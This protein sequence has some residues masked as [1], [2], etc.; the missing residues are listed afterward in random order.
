MAKHKSVVKPNRPL[1]FVDESGDAGLKFES[2]SSPFF[3]VTAVVFDS[4]AESQRCLELI[5]QLRL[6]EQMSARDEFHFN[7]CD[8]SQRARFLAAIREFDFHFS[9]VVI[10]KRNLSFPTKTKSGVVMAALADTAAREL[11]PAF[12]AAN[13]VIDKG[14]GEGFSR[15]LKKAMMNARRG[16]ESDFRDVRAERS[17]SNSL[18]QLADMVCG[19][20]SRQFRNRDRQSEFIE[21]IRSKEKSEIVC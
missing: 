9:S 5:A 12:S 16:D 11:V 7:K 19:A 18:I 13:V 10:N 3:V 15:Y 4:D 17:H 6:A 14:D 8:N 20:V 21:M 2:G 1:A